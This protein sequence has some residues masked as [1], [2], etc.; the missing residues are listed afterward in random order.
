MMAGLAPAEVRI[1]Q[2]DNSHSG[3]FWTRSD[4]PVRPGHHPP[5]PPPTFDDWR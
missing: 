1:V 4:G 2:A 3:F 5:M